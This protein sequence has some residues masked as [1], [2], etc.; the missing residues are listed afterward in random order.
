MAV[1]R[2]LVAGKV[3]VLRLT[4]ASAYVVYR[5]GGKK[6]DQR[7]RRGSE[8]RNHGFLFLAFRMSSRRW[9]IPG[10][11]VLCRRKCT[12]P[13]V[14]TRYLSCGCCRTSD[15]ETAL[16]CHPVG[17]TSFVLIPVDSAWRTRRVFHA[18]FSLK[19]S[20]EQQPLHQCAAR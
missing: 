16:I 2:A 6:R 4:V 20:Q 1:S 19:G 3:C 14:E 8:K 9:R 12:T 7:E 18:P 17:D 5:D 10:G 13:L 15:D 11:L